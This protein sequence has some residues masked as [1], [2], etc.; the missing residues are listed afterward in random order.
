MSDELKDQ[1]LNRLIVNWIKSQETLQA[2]RKHPY[3]LMLIQILGA[4]PR[5]QQRSNIIRLMEEQRRQ[6][7]LPFVKKFE[8][9]VQ[10]AYNRH[11]EHSEVFAKKRSP[12]ERPLFYS[13]GGKG[14]GEWG[15]HVT[16]AAAWAKKKL[17]S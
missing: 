10:A 2:K 16:E 13:V 7:G 1:D 3:V 17:V 14:T 15:L 4:S 8:E 9:A 6:F 12:D 5:G 11:S